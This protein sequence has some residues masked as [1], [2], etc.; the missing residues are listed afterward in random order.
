MTSSATPI[1]LALGSNL[2]D[3]ASH[4]R[5]AV[6]GLR[7]AG[8]VLERISRLY[9]T[10]PVG[11]PPQGWFLN[12]ALVGRFAGSP[13]ALLS[14]CLDV[15][16]GLGRERTVKNGPRTIDI[17]ILFYGDAVIVAPVLRI[18]HPRLHLRRFV[19]APLAQIAPEWTHP[20]L[21]LTATQ[22]LERC[23]DRSEV[24]PPQPW[25]AV[26]LA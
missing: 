24:L 11:G 12:A 10:E 25:P 4:L 14:T 18:P 13:H 9:G 26:V 8:V 17:D 19:L 6:E 22:L 5:S 2:G 21:R 1:G 16:R 7:R 20:A 3:R 15:E 23:E